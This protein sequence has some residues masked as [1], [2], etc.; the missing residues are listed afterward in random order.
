MFLTLNNSNKI[1][2]R[3]NQVSLE[4]VENEKKKFIKCKIIIEGKESKKQ[5][6][7]TLNINA[8]IKKVLDPNAN[9]PKIYTEI[10]FN[11]KIPEFLIYYRK[12]CN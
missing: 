3:K 4:N 7:I 6:E 11:C 12:S 1:K 9:K 5:E 8:A 2:K 10:K